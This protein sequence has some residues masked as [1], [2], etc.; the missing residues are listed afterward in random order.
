MT[1]KLFI[2]SAPSG[3]GKTSLARALIANFG[4]ATMSV[5]HTTRLRRTGETEGVDYHFVTQ[6][7]FLGMADQGVF[8][9]YAEVYGNY[10]G[11]SRVAVQRKL[12]ADTHVLLDI[13]WQGARL[14]RAQMPEAVS[15]SILPPSV[16]ELERRLRSRGSDSEDVIQ[17]RMQQALDEMQHCREAD[18]IV[19]NDDFNQALDDLTLILA[20]ESDR[21][22][23]L[24]V[25]LDELLANSGSVG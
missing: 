3:A 25:D 24:T 19:M 2:I 12:D 7:E 4:N 16:G 15:I 10:Y 1:G 21:I 20:G 6:S 18:F 13:D 11:T 23:P 22:R 5:S 14:V 9:E 17:N 8:L